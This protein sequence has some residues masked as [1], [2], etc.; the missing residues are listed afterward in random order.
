MSDVVCSHEI[1][2]QKFDV[3]FNV[4]TKKVFPESLTK[5]VLE[6]ERKGLKLYEQFIEERKVGSK[7]IWKSSIR[8]SSQSLQIT[9]WLPERFETNL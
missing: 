6:I 2:F 4:L 5:E 3:V 9:S 7:S 8:E 1:N